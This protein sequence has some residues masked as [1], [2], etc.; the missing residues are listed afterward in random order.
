MVS[1][2]PC[3]IAGQ[4][5]KN[6]SSGETAWVDIKGMKHPFSGEKSKSCS[7]DP[8]ELSA[9]DYNL[10]PTGS[11]MGRSDTCLA[12]DVNPTLYNKLQSLS[13]QI[14]SKSESISKSDEFFKSKQFP[15]T[16]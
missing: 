2:Q 5:I 9:Q 7:S 12:L 4:I 8:I 6:S 15:S 16:K 14:K 3:K 13:G 10:I 11:A 1:G